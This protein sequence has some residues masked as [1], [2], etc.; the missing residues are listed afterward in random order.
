M[1]LDISPENARSRIARIVAGVGIVGLCCGAWIFFE[2]SAPTPGQ[3]QSKPS[4]TAQPTASIGQAQL[5][6]RRPDLPS[7]ATRCG[8]GDLVHFKE[9]RVDASAL[10]FTLVQATSRPMTPALSREESRVQL[11]V[12]TDACS[13]IAIDVSGT[14]RREDVREPWFSVPLEQL[15]DGDLK[16]RVTAFG[17]SDQLFLR[18]ADGTRVSFLPR[19]LRRGY[20]HLPADDEQIGEMVFATDPCED[21]ETP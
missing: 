2:T 19:Q 20:R 5:V 17:L 13:K 16:V 10:R 1:T 6:W 21:K 3:A 15:P 18:K 7:D 14:L 11:E 8:N 12:T 4:R 9:M